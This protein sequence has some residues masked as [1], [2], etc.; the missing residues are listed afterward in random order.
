M[1]SCVGE[2]C[3][4]AVGATEA[5]DNLSF[6]EHH[7]AKEH[8]QRPKIESK[9]RTTKRSFKRAFNRS[10]RDGY[11]MYHG[12]IFTPQDFN[13]PI[14]TS[15]PQV[16][17]SPRV[18]PCQ[19][20]GASNRL[21]VF[22]WNCGGLSSDKY[23]CLQAWLLQHQFDIVCLQESHWRF[24]STWKT[25]QFHAIHT[26][27][28]SC[29]SGILLLVSTRVSSADS[30]TWTERIAGRLLHV[31]LRGS[32]QNLDIIACYQH[33]HRPKDMQDRMTFWDELSDT[34]HG[35]PNRNRL[36]M[37]GDFNTS[38]PIANSKVGIE[39]FNH[40]QQRVAGPQHRDWKQL[41][42]LIE[43]FDLIPINTWPGTLGPTFESDQGASRIDYILCRAIHCDQQSKD[44]KLLTHHPLVQLHGC[45]HYP[46][47]STLISRWIP[48]KS[49]SC[50]HW[51][52]H[53]KREVYEHYQQNTVQW[54]SQLQV[55]ESTI[56]SMHTSDIVDDYS[57]LHQTIHDCIDLQPVTAAPEQLQV[58]KTM[59]RQFLYHADALRRL[60]CGTILHCFQAWYHCSKKSSL[61]QA[62]NQK[63]KEVRKLRQQDLLR[64]AREAAT[65]HDTRSF[66][67]II[68]RLSPKTPKQPIS[69]RS[70][71]GHLLGVDEAAD[72]L[73]R[74]FQ[75]MYSDHTQNSQP[76]QH[77]PMTWPF[78][79]AEIRKSLKQLSV[80][81]AVAP[82]Y[83]PAPYWRQLEHVVAVK[84]Q[85]Y[86]QLCAARGWWPEE[87]G[88]SSI[89]FLSKPSKKANT[90]ANL[91]P[92]SLLEPCGKI[93]MNILGHR[94]RAQV[95]DQLLQYPIF[96]Y[97]PG[98]G[99][100]DATRRLI[101]HCS[102]TQHHMEMFQHRIHQQSAGMEPDLSGG[103]VLSLDLSRAFDE[104]PRAG[105]FRALHSL[106]IDHSLIQFLE[107]VYSHTKFEFE[108]QGE[109]RSFLASKG[110]RQGCSAAPTL[111]A[112]YTLELLTTLEPKVTK[113]W[114]RRCLTLYADDICAHVEFWSLPE[115]HSHLRKLGQLLDLL[116]Q[117]GMS[118]NVEKTTALIK[119]TGKLHNKATSQ[120]IRRT[121]EGAFLLIPRAS[122]TFTKVKLKS[123][124]LYL[125][126][127]ISYRNIT[128][129]TTD[130]R[131]AAARKSL[132]ILSPWLFKRHGLPRFR[133]VQ[134]WYQ[135]V[136]PSLTSGLLA[137]GLDQ[138]SLALL[139]AFS[140]KCF[141]RMYQQPVHLDHIPN[142]EFLEQHHIRDPL[143]ALRALCIKT[144]Q[145]EQQRIHQLDCSDILLF[146][147]ISANLEH[148]EC[149]LWHIE[150]CLE[151]R[152]SGVRPSNSLEL[153]HCHLCDRQFSTLTGLNEHIFK[154][155]REF[156]GRL[157]S[158]R[159]AIDQQQGLPTCS[160]CGKHFTTWYGLKTHIEYRCLLP[161]VQVGHQIVQTHRTSLRPMLNTPWDISQHPSLCRYLA[162]HCIL[163]GQFIN[164]KT[165]LQ[166][167]W[168]TFH[169]E[170]I[171]KLADEL[172]PLQMQCNN[173]SPCQFCGF[174]FKVSHQCPILKN[175]ALLRLDLSLERKATMAGTGAPSSP[176][177]P[178]CGRGPTPRRRIYFDL[179]KDQSDSLTC[180]HCETKFTAMMTLRR[181]IES[182]DCP[183]YNPG[184]A[185]ALKCGIHTEI[186]Q[187]IRDHMPSTLLQS[188]EN[189]RLLNCRCIICNQDFTRRQELVRHLSQQHSEVLHSSDTVADSIADIC[190]G[191][192]YTC[193]CYPERTE[194][195][196]NQRPKHRCVIF[197]QI[198][199]L[200]EVDQVQFNYS[201][202]QMDQ[203]YSATLG[204]LRNNPPGA[205]AAQ[206]PGNT[207]DQYFNRTT[208]MT[209]GA[210]LENQDIQDIFDSPLRAPH[211]KVRL[212]S[213]QTSTCAVDA[214]PYQ[215]DNG[216]SEN[217]SEAT[218]LLF[219]ADRWISNIEDLTVDFQSPE[220]QHWHWVITANFSQ[221]GQAMQMS[222]IYSTL[223]PTTPLK[224]A[225]GHYGLCLDDSAVVRLLN[226]RC[227]LCDAT[228]KS[229]AD[230]LAHHQMAH[231]LIPNWFLRH[232]HLGMKCLQYH[233]QTLT[234]EISDQDIYQLC[235][236]LI[237]RIQC[238]S[239]L[240]DGGD[241]WL[242]GDGRH[243][244]GS[245]SK[246]TTQTVPSDGGSK[247]RRE[248]TQGDQVRE[249]EQWQWPQ[250][251]A[252]AD[253][254]TA[255]DI[256]DEARGHLTLPE[257]RLGVC[258][259]LQLGPGGDSA[260]AHEGQQRM[261]KQQGEAR[262]TSPLS[263][264]QD[265]RSPSYTVLEDNGSTS[266]ERP[267]AERHQVW[268]DRSGRQVPLLELAQGA[269]KA[270]SFQIS[271]FD[272]GG[273]HGDVEH[274][275]EQHPGPS[276]DIEVP[277]PAEIAGGSLTCSTVPMD[278]VEPNPLR[279]LARPAE[280]IASLKLATHT[281]QPTTRQSSE[282]CSS[283][284]APTEQKLTLRLCKNI[285][286]KS[287]YINSVA[288]GLAWSS[289]EVEMMDEDWS[290]GGFFLTTCVHP[291]L[292]PLD[293]HHSFK[294]LLGDWLT[295]E[296]INVQHDATE[297]ARYLFS[298]LQP[299]AFD[300]T[301]WPKWSLADGPAMDQNLD[302]YPRGGKWDALS[303]T[304]PTADS[305]SLHCSDPFSLQQLINQWHDASGMCNVCIHKS[306]GKLLHVDRQV[307]SVKDLRQITSTDHVLIPHSDT[308]QDDIHWIT[309]EAVAMT[310]HLGQH[311]ESGHYRTLVQVRG[312]GSAKAWKD[313]ED[314]KLPDDFQSP[315][316]HHLSNVTLIWMKQKPSFETSNN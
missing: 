98:R 112:L 301:W 56:A 102:S 70:Q 125:G 38:L 86:G 276:C 248:E 281:G 216:S 151:Y 314:S 137:T 186:L 99:T 203:R 43:R 63:S 251:S 69:L 295:T 42:N 133:R 209:A 188:P 266:G 315:T 195:R 211:G 156:S 160:R 2:G 13:M 113:E 273:D 226:S 213:D 256:S 236:V 59:F 3:G 23:Q 145:R 193:F 298:K 45:R 212:S 36:C 58:P 100:A 55:L 199:A 110:I 215:D 283:S 206:A 119:L 169:P 34:L 84:L 214:D 177:Q 27:D 37:M 83:A 194:L 1:T 150:Q 258:G 26:G 309:Y 90:P 68:R 136:F 184:K 143:K 41:L 15:T 49:K 92:I 117:Y 255:A 105:L 9:R 242:R 82:H 62:M 8:G 303:L 127:M 51:N 190:R 94:M 76:S 230:L 275:Q 142:K 178:S 93:L 103:I 54:T 81:K 262:T 233:L 312:A 166:T 294:S 293:V 307:Q 243:L 205:T 228:L 238:I 202:I 164:S 170:L 165:A 97:V 40:H 252:P 204:A 183:A 220:F 108:F 131:I 207:L 29:H 159:P 79:L 284:A 67:Q 316:K 237:F 245:S 279:P 106:G 18:S 25:E 148:L 10:I 120:C 153:Y 280:I 157:R 201:I 118:I 240:T 189:L 180:G 48:H 246:R 260:R 60:S 21:S 124:Q 50:F 12:K 217:D 167:H 6:L 173:R 250:H 87:W 191:P 75:A 254:S 147:T 261:E 313:Y 288:L 78:S 53:R 227:F 271:S 155:H 5:V 96:A 80:F 302:D 198:A 57:L 31:R 121:R 223:Y 28:T 44:V 71:Q 263:C 210:T 172:P 277:Q 268:P 122:G 270:G 109:Y 232:F 306:R 269:T 308:Y 218:A 241:G 32:T 282:K 292:V 247:R 17:L 168:K 91:R 249:P 135:C 208:A 253:S 192:N 152:R 66:F 104:V 138:H 139:D 7:A 65:A 274:H 290:D 285:T 219:D 174:H 229:G 289:L 221:L 16:K 85:E 244:G 141:R 61:R 149:C 30:I 39:T 111:W 115:L 24:T 264:L 196:P 114:I 197:T 299:A 225:G 123:A 291:T 128:R 179:L 130:C 35:I 182:G 304:L 140:I 257:P 22:S 278:G 311:V 239:F 88:T 267:T 146:P 265:D 72:E 162:T 185:R 116:E 287:C 132:G 181:H 296:R 129:L 14:P 47:V 235:Q 74:W 158:Y 89:T 224:L 154:Q 171:S 11:T 305:G 144:I 19:P 77:V 33:V 107:K 222:P 297:F 134:L 310:Y 259:V 101:Q 300:M 73:C 64:Q 95:I 126:V 200:M 163:C 176:A 161:P 46:L 52:R 272:D 20:S 175:L 4:T 286:G 231:G 234:I 187:A